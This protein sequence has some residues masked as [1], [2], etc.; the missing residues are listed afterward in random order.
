MGHFLAAVT[1]TVGYSDTFADPRG[2]H[3]NRRPLH[4]THFWTSPSVG[5]LKPFLMPFFKP[6]CLL[7]DRVPTSPSNCVTLP[8]CALCLP[9]FLPSFL[10]L[11]PSLSHVQ[12]LHFRLEEEGKRREEVVERIRGSIL[13][14]G[15]VVK[16]K[17]S[18][19]RHCPHTNI[20]LT[21]RIAGT[22][23]L[24]P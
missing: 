11:L 13:L 10:L 23:L 22:E 5:N 6:K 21:K 1:V 12:F 14:C 7:H 9:S 15:R 16:L 8:I 20:A 2:C 17:N 4:C 19:R 18:L 3:C 24:P